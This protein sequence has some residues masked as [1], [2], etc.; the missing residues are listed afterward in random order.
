M[1]I[2]QL[3]YLNKP[4]IYALCNAQDCKI[5]IGQSVNMLQGI[6]RLLGDLKQD[7]KHSGLLSDLEKINIIILE[8]CPGASSITLRTKLRTHVQKYEAE[9]YS[10]YRSYRGLSYKLSVTI[11]DDFNI[12]VK[13]RSQSN[14]TTVLGV[15]STV[16]EADSFIARSFPDDTIQSLVY[17]YNKL[18]KEYYNQEEYGALKRG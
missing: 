3:L 16:K 6:T 13:A 10:L 1:H 7:K 4:G 18:T 8:T 15:F 17:S 5:Y 9:G 11:G 12:Y 14:K 2:S